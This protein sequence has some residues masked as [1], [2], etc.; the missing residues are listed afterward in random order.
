MRTALVFLLAIIGASA[1]WA[2]A[3]APEAPRD[4]V[5]LELFTSQGCSSCPP[6]DRLAEKLAQEPGFVVISRPVTYWDRLGWKDS[7][8]RE[9]NTALQRAYA[10][11]GFDPQ[12][13]YTPQVVVDGRAGTIGSQEGAI[14]RLA[15]TVPAKG[16]AA[17]AVERLDAGGTAVG[18]GGISSQPAELVLLA[19]S[20][21]ESVAIGRGENGGRRI[22]YTNVVRSER[23]LAQWHGGKASLVLDAKSRRVAAGQRQLLLL[24]EQDGGPVLASRWL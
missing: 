2:L 19:I 9:E 21:G 7:L 5:V 3:D 14:R 11:R 12:R 20:P 10:R 1:A 17:I 6:A 16:D 18:L 23:R 8:A 13:V 22:T 24:R 15:A 4:P